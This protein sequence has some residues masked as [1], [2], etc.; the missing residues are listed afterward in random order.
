MLSFN[1]KLPEIAQAE[2][3]CITIPGNDRI[4]AGTY[5]FVES[6]CDDKIVIAGGF[7]SMLFRSNLPKF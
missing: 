2:T 1:A 6:Y 5:G 3:R 4:S 7:L